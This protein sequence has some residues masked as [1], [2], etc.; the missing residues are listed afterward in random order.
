MPNP[1][2]PDIPDDWEQ[3]DADGV[4]YL[5]GIADSET[6]WRST[7]ALS[8]VTDDGGALITAENDRPVFV[9]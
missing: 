7:V 8:P 1:S 5:L 6:A 2:V 9:E 3:K 4:P